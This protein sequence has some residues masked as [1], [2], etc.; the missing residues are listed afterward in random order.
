MGCHAAVGSTID[1]TFALARKVSGAEGWGYI[2]IKGMVDA[3]NIG[4]TRGEIL[5]YLAR[6]GGGSEFRENPEMLARW[7]QQNGMVD[8]EKVSA[9]DVYELITP[10]AERALQLNKAYTHIVR[11]QSYIYGRDATWVPVN[12]VFKSVDETTPILHNEHRYYG[13]DIRLDWSNA[14]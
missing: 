13:W 2:N 4:E 6:A 7:F 14:E 1:Q 5:N 11:N 10:S 9:A 8:E 12:N 3:P